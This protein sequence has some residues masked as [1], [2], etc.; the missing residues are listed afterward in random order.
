M[1]ATNSYRMRRMRPAFSQNAALR[2]DDIANGQTVA[3]NE[4]REIG[5]RRDQDEASAK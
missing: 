1:T 3:R 5:Q 4:G 2:L